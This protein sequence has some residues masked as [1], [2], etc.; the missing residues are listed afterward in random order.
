LQ[1]S[2]WGKDVDG[3]DH[4]TGYIENAWLGDYISGYYTEGYFM[5]EDYLNY[6]TG[7]SLALLTNASIPYGTDIQ[8]QFSN[9]NV[10]WSDNEGVPLDA[11]FLNAGFYS[12]DLRNLNYSD[13]FMIHNFTGTLALTPRVYQSRLITTEGIENGI[14]DDYAG[15]LI[16]GLILGLILGIGASRA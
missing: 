11:N 2:N 13:I 10:T 3:A 16:V 5:T 12:I 6:T 8:V 1:I 14:G 7:N 15:L 9:D 4:H